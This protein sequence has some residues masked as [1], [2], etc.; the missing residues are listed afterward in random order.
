MKKNKNN[1]D[2]IQKTL[3]KRE[4]LKNHKLPGTNLY[5]ILCLWSCVFGLIL[6]S[7]CNS[8]NEIKKYKTQIDNLNKEKTQLTNQVEQIQ[9]ENEQLKKQVS[10]LQKLPDN[11]KG[12]N[13]YQLENVKIHNYS[14]LYDENKD[15][16]LDT[17]VVRIQPMD[18]FGDLIKAAGSVEIELWNLNKT[19]SQAQIGKWQVGPEELKKTWNN[20]LI[21]N[22][23][24]NFNIS[25]KITK[26][27]EPLTIKMIFTDYLSGKVFH[28]QKV[29]EP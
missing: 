26:F 2:I 27:D 9:S 17:L 5:W 15:G 24:L 1:K 16:K 14:S 3:G 12:T 10:E 8:E 21:T 28:E 4:L 13:L 7:G 25:E 29:I 11:V 23:R 6:S 18:S 22:Y 19:E 20:I